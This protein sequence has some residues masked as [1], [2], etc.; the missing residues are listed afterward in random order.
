MR[1]GLRIA[2]LAR[3]AEA[4]IEYGACK[5]RLGLRLI[6]LATSLMDKGLVQGMFGVFWENPEDPKAMSANE[7][8]CSDIFL[9]F[10]VL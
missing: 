1:E 3:A 4:W 6:L 8:A 7:C 9:I 10:V 2:A 5:C